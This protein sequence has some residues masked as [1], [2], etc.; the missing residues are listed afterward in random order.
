M[1][2]GRERE[3]EL[4]TLMPQVRNVHSQPHNFATRRPSRTPRSP[5]RPSNQSRQVRVELCC[6]AQDCVKWTSTLTHFAMNP[7]ALEAMPTHTWLTAGDVRESP[8]NRTE[9]RAALRR[10]EAHVRLLRSLLSPEI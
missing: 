6:S 7:A 3:A 5:T 1:T 10:A 2:E 4:A 8:P 9:L